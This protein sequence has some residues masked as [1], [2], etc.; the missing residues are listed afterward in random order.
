MAKK[1]KELTLRQMFLR[2]AGQG[3][4]NFDKAPTRINVFDRARKIKS[5]NMFIHLVE[6]ENITPAEALVSV[7]KHVKKNWNQF[8]IIKDS[9]Q[10]GAIAYLLQWEEKLKRKRLYDSDELKDFCTWTGYKIPKSYKTFEN[11]MTLFRDVF[12]KKRDHSG[13]YS[14]ELL[15]K[16][17]EKALMKLEKIR[18]LNKS[19]R[20]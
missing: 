20:S 18:K 11:E 7:L 9:D 3:L 14:R 8:K 4:E 16:A 6:Q 19:S 12:G 17:E 13:K 10:R 15:I 1:K 2:D 5:W